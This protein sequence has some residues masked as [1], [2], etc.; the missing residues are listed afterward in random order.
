MTLKKK[1]N[2]D[3]PGIKL[4]KNSQAFKLLLRIKGTEV[5]IELE[6]SY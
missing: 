3:L 2:I 5:V 1:Q 6:I 4:L